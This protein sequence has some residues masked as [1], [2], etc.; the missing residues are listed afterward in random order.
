MDALKAL[1]ARLGA[2]CVF[3]CAKQLEEKYRPQPQPRLD[4][5][6]V[7]T[8]RLPS[9]KASLKPWQNTNQPQTRP[10]ADGFSFI[11]ARLPTLKASVTPRK[12]TDQLQAHSR[13]DDSDI[14]TARLPSMFASTQPR[15][16][17]GRPRVHRSSRPV[18]TSMSV[19]AL[20][21]GITRI[22]SPKAPNWRFIPNNIYPP[23]FKARDIECPEGEWVSTACP[24]PT[25]CR[26]YNKHSAHR[27]TIVIAVDGAC[28]DNGAYD[29]VSSRA[30]YVGPGKQIQLRRP[31]RRLALTSGNTAAN[32]PDRRGGGCHFGC[33]ASLRDASDVLCRRKRR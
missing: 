1:I 6:N 21:R 4:D 10:Q 22:S 11:T 33:V 23:S 13:V 19:S 14:I 30:A 20:P 3:A 15:K 7:V 8:A 28:M 2:A 9:V 17:E 26:K 12:M 32:E 31:R 18:T 29:A 25:K 24:G 27:S 16:H 5:S